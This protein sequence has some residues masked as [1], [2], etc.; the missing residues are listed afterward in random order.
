[1]HMNV[2]HSCCQHHHMSRPVNSEIRIMCIKCRLEVGTSKSKHKI[3]QYVF[4]ICMCKLYMVSY[5]PT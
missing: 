1:M 2:W 5:E 3:H 4:D